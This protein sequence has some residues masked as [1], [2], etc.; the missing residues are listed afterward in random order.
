MIAIGNMLYSIDR[1]SLSKLDQ[2]KKCD[3]RRDF[4]Q[5]LSRISQSTQKQYIDMITD[6]D[7][8]ENKIHSRGFTFL[9]SWYRHQI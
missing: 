6:L 8:L 3:R 5:Y 9:L 4:G 7:K 2:G 1:M